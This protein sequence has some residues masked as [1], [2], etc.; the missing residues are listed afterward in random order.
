MPGVDRGETHYVGDDC[1][2]GHRDMTGP[3]TTAELEALKM[4]LILAKNRIADLERTVAALRA[5]VAE[6]DKALEEA[7]HTIAETA[8]ALIVV[9][10]KLKEPYPDHPSLSP[11]TRFFDRHEGTPWGLL[12]KSDTSLRAAL[13]LTEEEMLKRGEEEKV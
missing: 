2:G 8:K 11:W 4:L 10:P 9:M 7:R 3:L 6:K 12:G 13:A 1:S 5:L